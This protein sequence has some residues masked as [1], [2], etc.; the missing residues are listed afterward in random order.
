MAKPFFFIKYSINILNTYSI[1]RFCKDYM[2]SESILWSPHSVQKLHITYS[3][4]L[5]CFQLI[6]NY[7]NT[8]II[9]NFDT[10]FQNPVNLSLS[11]E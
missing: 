4:N 2:N 1:Y 8:F 3:R 10:A 7:N 5:L 11:L 6:L 9:T